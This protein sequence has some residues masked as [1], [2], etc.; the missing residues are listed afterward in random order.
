MNSFLRGITVLA[1]VFFAKP[2]H[3]TVPQGS[4]DVV[5]S[6][7]NNKIVKL[8]AADGTVLWSVDVANNAVL[9]VDPT[10]LSVYAGDVATSSKITADGAVSSL[11]PAISNYHGAM[12]EDSPTWTGLHRSY[13]DV[14]PADGMLYLAGGDSQSQGAPTV[15]QMNKFTGVAT[16]WRVDLSSYIKS[17]DALAVQPWKGGYIYAASAASSKVV[18]VDPATRSVV[19]TFDTAISPRFMAINPDGGNVY[20]ADGQNPFVVAYS[21]TGGLA[22]VNL[23]LGGTVSNIATPKGVMGSPAIAACPAPTVRVSA[24]ATS[25]HK[26]HSATITFTIK[27]CQNVTVMYSVVTHAQSGV[28]YL[29]TDSLGN[30]ITAGGQSFGPLTLTSLY[31]SRRRIL[32]ISILLLP[33]PAYYRGNVKATVQLL[34]N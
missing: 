29:L 4:G 10:D 21:P 22:W 34:G 25:L 18:V 26:G 16:N 6:V 13:T 28:D 12:A 7:D 31:N 33:D 14:N 3:A 2:V 27:G 30:V 5:V 11:A 1:L 19:T 8:N 17:L 15:Y 20:I 9:K 24:D 32:P 23:N